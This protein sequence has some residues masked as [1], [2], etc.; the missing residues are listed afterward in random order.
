[1]IEKDTKQPVISGGTV[2]Y[3]TPTGPKVA[4]GSL[5]AGTRE[6]T[7]LV[8]TDIA[9]TARYATKPGIAFADMTNTMMTTD[10]FE[11]TAVIKGLRDGELVTCY[12]KAQDDLGNVDTSDY[13]VVLLAGNPAANAK[14]KTEFEAESGAL[15]PPTAVLE[16]ATASGGK[17]IASPTRWQGS[18]SYKL[19][20][21]ETGEYIIWARTYGPSGNED[22]YWVSVDGLGEDVFDIAESGYA[23]WTWYRV[24]GRENRKDNPSGDRVFVLAKGDHTLTFRNREQ[25]ARL[26]KI[27]ITSDPAFVPEGYKPP[28][29][30]KD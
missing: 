7:I 27:I 22:S 18:A 13:A 26:D 1:V 19:T 6:A 10:K 3:A 15:T 29:E 23:Q 14:F 24:K 21:P 12:V 4:L 28:A 16:D 5:P 11:H 25:N 8:R 30:K 2:R 9:A 17:Y 20:V